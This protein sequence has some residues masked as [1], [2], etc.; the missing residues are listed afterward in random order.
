MKKPAIPPCADELWMDEQF[1]DEQLTKMG[2]GSELS[3][4]RGMM[5]K[6]LLMYIL[7]ATR[8]AKKKHCNTMFARS[9]RLQFPF[10]QNKGALSA[11][12]MLR[13]L[14]NKKY[15]GR[16]YLLAHIQYDYT[17]QEYEHHITQLRT[18]MEAVME[19]A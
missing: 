1:V 19:A 2:W 12:S 14:A 5:T 15:Q 18:F 6:R 7:K 16:V 3:S 8:V 10:S 9:M 17:D 11:G 4:A 13:F